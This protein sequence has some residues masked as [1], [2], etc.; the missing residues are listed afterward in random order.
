MALGLKLENNAT[1]ALS[2]D[3]TAAATSLIL[4]TGQGN[5]FPIVGTNEYTYVTIQKSDGNWEIVKCESRTNGSDT[6]ATLT[7]NIDSSTGAAQA[8]SIGDIVSLRPVVQIIEDLATLV[9]T[10][11]GKLEAPSGTKM[12]FYQA[13]APTGWTIDATVAD[14]LIA[15]KGGSQAFNAAAGTLAGTWTVPNHTHNLSSHTHNLASHTHAG[16]NHNHQIWEEST[17]KVWDASGNALA[18]TT[19]A[20]ANG[21]TVHVS[22]GDGYVDSY[23]DWYSKNE[24]T[25]QT[26]APSNNNSG[27]PSTSTSGNGTTPSTYRPYA[28]LCIVA[29]KDA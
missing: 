21:I 11:E 16:P 6:F 1:G 28:A 10:Y 3:I 24:G 19:G 12:V 2:A 4:E 20:K 29:S 18:I 17:Y 14:A 22:G 27:G 13:A 26:G 5:L 25:G 23:N 15:I 9:D 7:R 8:F